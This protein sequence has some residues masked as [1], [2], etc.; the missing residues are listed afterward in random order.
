[1]FTNH[2]FMPDY[3]LYSNG[4]NSIF[5]VYQGDHPLIS[6]LHNQSTMG[7]NIT[8]PAS[9]PFQ[10]F[11]FFSSFKRGSP[12]RASNDLSMSPR[13]SI[14]STLR[15]PAAKPNNFI[16]LFNDCITT[17]SSRTQEYLLFKD[18]EDKF[19]PSPEVLTQVGNFILPKKT[20]DSTPLE[21]HSIS[22][23]WPLKT[24]RPPNRSS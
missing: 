20:E 24:S 10:N 22:F 17:A 4:T 2:I 15:P 18:P 11:N 21:F 19:H 8:K 13:P 5:P 3:T 16:T 1:M 9:N 14:F 23:K 12:S 7:Q 6:V